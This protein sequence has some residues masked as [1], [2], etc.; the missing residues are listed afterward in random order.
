MFGSAQKDLSST[1]SHTMICRREGACRKGGR[2]SCEAVASAWS[3]S[4]AKQFVGAF[5][6]PIST[7][8]CVER[9]MRREVWR[10]SAPGVARFHI[11]MPPEI[12]WHRQTP[13]RPT[14]NPDPVHPCGSRRMRSDTRGKLLRH[15]PRRPRPMCPRSITAAG[16]RSTAIATSTISPGRT[17]NV[18]VARCQPPLDASL[19]HGS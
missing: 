8:Q 18:R 4:H 11:C 9:R 13:Q 19:W 5:L 2:S 14:L 12:A 6:R 15:D 17:R 10:T 1:V 7:Q 3:V 16:L